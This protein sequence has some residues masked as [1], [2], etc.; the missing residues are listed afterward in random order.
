MTSGRVKGKTPKKTP[1]RKPKHGRGLLRIGGTNKGG[2]GRPPDEFK[3]LCRQL[4]S[5]E[6]TIANVQKILNNPRHAQ[7]LPA[8]RWATE[9]G[10]G[11]PKESLELS[12]DGSL[13]ALIA[14]AY[15]RKDA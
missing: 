5:G 4:A 13:S 14:G 11:K 3:E 6:I 7:F 12:A 1:M 10:Y 15:R 9:N 8:L 2:P